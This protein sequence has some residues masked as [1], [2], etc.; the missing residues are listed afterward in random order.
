MEE[1]VLGRC[2]KCKVQKEMKNVN[3]V[4][5]KNGRSAV[6][7][8]CVLCGTNMFRILGKTK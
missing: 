7:G 8:Q 5:M 4:T 3:Y 2:M 6:K 1:K